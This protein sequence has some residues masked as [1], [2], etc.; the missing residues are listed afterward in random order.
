LENIPFNNEGIWGRKDFKRRTRAE[1]DML[2]ALTQKTK[3]VLIEEG[4]D[5]KKIVIIGS[6][7]NTERFR[8]NER[9]EKSFM[10]KN[11]NITILFVGRL[12]KYKGVFEIIKAFNTLLSDASL[13]DYSLQLQ[14]IG[15]GSERQQLLDLEKELGID[16]KVIHKTAGYDDI[17]KI[18]QQADLFVAPS[19]DTSTWTEQYGYMLLEAQASG[20][21]IIT[22]DAGSITE[23]V[24]DGAL[25]IPQ[26]DA[27]A[28]YKQMKNLILNPSQRIILSQKSRKR[29]VS[30][31]DFKRKAEQI[32]KVYNAVL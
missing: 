25:Q 12:E 31:H 2:I 24:A 29:A 8:P 1:A 17:H 21:P 3:N 6:G 22:T 15:E 7:I 28:L 20:L 18:Y 11:K 5:E 14:M 10:Q 9:L 13:R 26:R 4:A 16:K 30:F 27:E 19:F 23:V 32:E